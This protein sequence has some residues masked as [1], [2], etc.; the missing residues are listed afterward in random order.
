[1]Q[2]A[3]KT[4]Q[5]KQG[6]ELCLFGNTSNSLV[7][8]LSLALSPDLILF[9]FFFG[10]GGVTILFDSFLQAS[11]CRNP[12][13][14]QLLASPHTPMLCK[15]PQKMGNKKRPGPISMKSSL[16]SRTFAVCTEF[17]SE[18]IWVWVQSPGYDSHLSM[19]WPRTWQS[20]ICV[21]TRDMTVTHPW[22]DL[23]QDSHPA[24]LC[25][26]VPSHVV[27]SHV[28]THPYRNPGHDSHPS[29]WWPR[30]WQ[31]PTNVVTQDMTV[32]HLCGDLVHDT[33]PSIC[34]PRTWQS[35]INVVTQDMTVTHQCGDPGHDSYPS[36]WWPRTW[37]SPI[38]VVTQDMSHP[39]MWWSRTWQSP[40][41]A[42]T[43]LLSF[44]LLLKANNLTLCHWRS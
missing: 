33:H 11:E 24:M 37:Q 16:I 19:W 25:P 28:V 2:N 36:M 4:R 14:F 27:S 40:I 13:H 12:T 34:W 8:L 10:G 41:N 21:V 32:T 23:G 35:P 26:V 9:W 29:L 22:G 43:T 7:S 31:T 15:H 1:M 18:E 20:P 17:N 42:V 38:N 5:P 6:K 39:L 30:T 3:C 44:T